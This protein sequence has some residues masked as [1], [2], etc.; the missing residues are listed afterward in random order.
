MIRNLP[1][2]TNIQHS[3]DTRLPASWTSRQRRQLVE[4]SLDA[5]GLRHVRNSVVGDELVRGISGGERRRVSIAIELVSAPSIL[6]LDEVC[7]KV[8]I[9]LIYNSLRRGWIVPVPR[10]LC[11]IYSL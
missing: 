1:V 3:A 8:L 10:M 11:C 4:E 9:V 5:L 7:H 6:F 2:H